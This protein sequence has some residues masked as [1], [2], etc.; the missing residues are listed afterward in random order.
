MIFF[1]FQYDFRLLDRKTNSKF[2]AKFITQPAVGHVSM[3]IY[4]IRH[5]Q[6]DYNVQQRFQ[7]QLDIPLN[8]TGRQQ[9]EKLR[10]YLLS[11]QIQ[12]Q[13][14]I[15]SPLSR[16]TETAEIIAKRHDDVLVEPC[17]VE[18]SLGAYDGRYES[19]LAEEIGKQDY[20]AW[21]ASCFTVPSPGGESMR[22]AK[23]RIEPLIEKLATYSR[24]M[25]LGV[26]AH[27]GILMA[28]KSVL[29]GKSDVASLMKFKQP[30]DEVDVWSFNNRKAMSLHRIDY[31]IS[32]QSS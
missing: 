22:D 7:S 1:D 15:S 25:K 9:A 24:D 10:Q 4:F 19:E 13:P 3:L 20:D 32:S 16:A 21:R 30:N 26:V 5:G 28:C 2:N 23:N 8:R 14:I 11:N 6:T 31:Q 12:L 29:S 17:L 27:Q 18:I